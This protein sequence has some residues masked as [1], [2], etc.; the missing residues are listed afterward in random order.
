MAHAACPGPPE[1]TA[2]ERSDV[3]D[4]DHFV[5]ANAIPQRRWGEAFAV[6]AAITTRGPFPL[7]AR[8]D[9]ADDTD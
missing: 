9:P 1:C 7:G 5:E 3:P 8:V 6:W 4:F 2:H